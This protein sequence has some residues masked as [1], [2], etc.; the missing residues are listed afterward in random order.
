MERRFGKIEVMVRE[1]GEYA[2]LDIFFISWIDETTVR[3]MR[4]QLGKEGYQW[5]WA[6]QEAQG[7]LG[8]PSVRIPRTFERLNVV[9]D[10]VDE[11]YRATG[12][13]AQTEAPDI[14]EVR[15]LE[16]HL[17]DLQKLLYG[18]D[19]AVLERGSPTEIRETEESS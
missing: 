12:V 17:E 13:K 9:Q 7:P 5:R 2:T 3:V 19:Y 8:M 14:N 18:F 6:E 11:I 10:L 1:S 4:P 15:R 16:N